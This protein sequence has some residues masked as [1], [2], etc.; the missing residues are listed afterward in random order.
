MGVGVGVGVRTGAVICGARL[1][2]IVPGV[3]VP[4]DDDVTVGFRRS[5]Q[6][7]DEIVRRHVGA[8]LA[9]RV[10]RHAHLNTE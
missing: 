4:A 6:L 10:D 1:A 3:Q 9:L 5:A 7:R 2:R 8:K